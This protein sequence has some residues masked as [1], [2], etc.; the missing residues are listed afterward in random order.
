MYAHRYHYTP[1]SPIAAADVP[2]LAL[3]RLAPAEE[4]PPT[5]ITPNWNL[6]TNVILNEVLMRGSHKS[7]AKDKP[8]ALSGDA[9]P[10]KLVDEGKDKGKLTSGKEI[11]WLRPMLVDSWYPSNPTCQHIERVLG[12]RAAHD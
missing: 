10:E 12:L 2:S 9:L 3:N 4:D 8:S 6:L 11:K 5:G 7:S 1:V